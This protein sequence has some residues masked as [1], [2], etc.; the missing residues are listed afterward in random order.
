MRL[1]NIHMLA[2][3]AALLAGATDDRGIEF[4]IRVAL[5]KKLVEGD[6]H[7]D[8][9]EVTVPPV[10][11]EFRESC[12]RICAAQGG[13]VPPKILRSVVHTLLGE[14]LQSAHALRLGERG[15]NPQRTR[16]ADRAKAWRRDIDKW[17]HLHYWERPDGT[18]ELASV[19]YHDD[20]SIPE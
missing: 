14:D 5:F 9:D 8:W 1:R 12:Q 17:L 15:S 7:P 6:G 16:A 4:A 2:A 11:G 18:V 19:V 10:G 13:A 3:A 20:F